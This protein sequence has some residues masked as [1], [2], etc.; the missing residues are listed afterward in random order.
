MTAMAIK[1]DTLDVV[2]R[3]ERGGF[4]REQARVQATVL[5]AVVNA[6]T[7]DA[8][9]RSDLTAAEDKLDTRIT[10]VEHRLETRMDVGERRLDARLT[11]IE[12][13]LEQFQRTSEGQ[14][15]LLRWMLGFVLAG[16]SGLLYR[17]FLRAVGR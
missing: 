10:H 9:T 12:H 3:L 11:S 5:A 7:L 2:E 4:S 8:A 16:T 14:Y 13:K 1:F 15:N 17:I 6:D